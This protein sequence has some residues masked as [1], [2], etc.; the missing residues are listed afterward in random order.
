MP[1][2]TFLNL[3]KDK[4]ELFIHAAKKEFSRV[5][6]YEASISNIIK[7]AGIPRGSF[8]Q[9]FDD[10]EDVYFFL[11]DEYSKRNHERFI[12]IIKKNNED[13]FD[14]YR[15]WFQSI[16][17][18][19]EEP[20]NR[21]YLKNT[22]LNMNYK[23]ERAFTQNM[24]EKRFKSRFF[25][26]IGLLNTQ[27]LNITNEEELYHVIK[28]MNAVTFQNL[29]H[30]FAKELSIDDAMKTFTLEIDL[31]KKGFYKGAE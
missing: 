21:H 20:E 5:P 9:Y 14:S 22:F 18:N 19:V 8:Y 31:L 7:D 6:L 2:Q 11:L 27:T 1:K 28:I 16:L 10:K 29:V 17:K 26:I 12:S 15:E 4:Q 25:E 30:A 13:L 3:S 23:I 24:I